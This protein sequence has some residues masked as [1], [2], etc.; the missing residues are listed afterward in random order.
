MQIAAEGTDWR[1]MLNST[2]LAVMKRGTKLMIAT[3]FMGV[4][5]VACVIGVDL[6][7]P[8]A[9]D[10][11]SKI[12]QAIVDY[13]GG[14]SG[15]EDN[16]SADGRR[17]ATAFQW[18][19]YSYIRPVEKATLLNAA[20]Q[21]MRE[22][23]PDPAVASDSDLI[24]AAI[25]G[26]LTSLDDYSVYLDRK[27][28]KRLYQEQ[29]DGRFGGLGIEIKKDPAGLEVISPIDGTPAMRAG[30]Q[31]GDRLTHADG[32][33]LADLTLREALEM[34][35]GKPGTTVTVTIA[36][37]GR[38]A[39]D[40]SLT[41]EIIRIVR[42]KARMK[43]DIGYIR[44]AHFLRDTGGDLRRK[45]QALKDRAGPG[46]LKG[47]VIDLRNNPGGLF[48]ESINVAGAF[49]SGGLIVST[50][51]RVKAEEFD[52]D[53][54]DPS[55]GLPLVVLINKGSASASE[56]V[57]GAIKYRDRGLIVGEKSF[58]KGSVQSTFEFHGGGGVKLT[59][60]LY[61]TPS[62]KTV[63]GGIEP[64]VASVDDPQTEEVDEALQTALEVVRD[65]G[66]GVPFSGVPAP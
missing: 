20:T 18:V 42:V 43:G 17:F 23:Y 57:A 56:I 29:I 26:M 64:N 13:R 59:T 2:M 36:R 61:Y 55:D 35:R 62:G 32:I 12:E 24:E 30:I 15:P 27:A 39:F 5:A 53:L 3:G 46:G 52:A 31:P 60:A 28:Y 1:T 44:I 40:I 19:R 66:G 7:S 37:R 34:L 41:R 11:A 38:D 63:D 58:G 47:F 16:G 21:G 4:V 22:T 25:Q 14:R 49:L 65:T 33:P 8:Q 6:P 50:R 45:M 10:A 9:R 51:S 54:T 48:D